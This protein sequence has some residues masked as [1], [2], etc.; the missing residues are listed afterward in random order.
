MDN[1]KVNKV[2]LELSISSKAL[3]VGALLTMPFHFILIP[4]NYQICAKR[5]LSFEYTFLTT[6]DENEFIEKWNKADMRARLKF[7]ENMGF[8]K[9]QELGIIYPVSENSNTGILN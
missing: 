3:I 8:K 9:L 6:N 4:Y 5:S 7:M 1:P 2:N